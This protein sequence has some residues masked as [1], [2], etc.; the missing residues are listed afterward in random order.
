MEHWKDIEGYEELYQVSDLGRIKTKK[1]LIRKP[2]LNKNGYLYVN[3][4]KDGKTHNIPVHR[5]VAIA[6]IEG[7]A[8]ELTVNHKNEDKTDNRAENLEWLTRR[9]NLN[10]GTHNTRM[11]NSRKGKCAGADHFNY[12]KLGADSHTHK[13]KVIGVSVNDPEEVVEFDT[14][15]DA[16]RALN[17]SSGQLSDTLNGKYKSCGGYYWRR[18]H[19]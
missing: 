16:S 19:E 15:A 5:L 3:L 1:G 6:F 7:Q 10:Y 12:G 4:R 8:P 14:A 17:I 9:E 13:G 2:T 18:L 11:R